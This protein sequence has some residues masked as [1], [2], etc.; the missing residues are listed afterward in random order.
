[1]KHK[2]N[3]AQAAT[4]VALTITLVGAILPMSVA[5]AEEEK[6]PRKVLTGWMPYYSVK[7]SMAAILANKD[8][9]S[10][11]SP[12]WYSLTSA[13]AIK[14][15]Y[16]SA[17]LTIPMNTQLDLLRAN[18]LKIIPAIT[19]GSKKL[20]LAGLLAKP[21]TRSQVVNTITKLVLTNNYDGI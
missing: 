3:L 14:D 21:S 16:A 12:F 9:M 7:N 2:S 4:A 6:L 13:T 18:G 11:V 19:D 20:V 15:Q 10:E 8:L 17:K 1:M 5:N